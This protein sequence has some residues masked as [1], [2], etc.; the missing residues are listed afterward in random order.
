MQ[1]PTRTFE[2]LV[3]GLRDPASAVTAANALADW[4]PSAIDTLSG[5]RA[6][7]AGMDED[8]RD[9]VVEAMRRIDP[10]VQVERVPADTVFSGV[11]HATTAL[12]ENLSDAASRRANERVDEYQMFRTWRTPEELVSLVQQLSADANPVAEAFLRGI[13]EKDP[14]LAARL[15]RAA[16]GSGR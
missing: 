5:M 1:S 10:T 2:D 13:A 14:E 9:R 4:G 8:S 16:G 7:L 15:R 3:A 11:V 12:P 6:A